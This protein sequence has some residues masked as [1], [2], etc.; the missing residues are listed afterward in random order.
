ML[1]LHVYRQAGLLKT[2]PPF[3]HPSMRGIK[4]AQSRF[5]DEIE[6]FLFI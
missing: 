2:T 3:G 5:F 1:I 6:L 4:K